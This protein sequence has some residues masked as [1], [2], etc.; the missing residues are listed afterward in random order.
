MS[1]VGCLSF[2]A[3]VSPLTSAIIPLAGS[4]LQKVVIQPYDS[5]AEG[6]AFRLYSFANFAHEVRW[7]M[8]EVR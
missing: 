2:I 5:V 3:S 8:L 4:L 6:E 7:K 1:D